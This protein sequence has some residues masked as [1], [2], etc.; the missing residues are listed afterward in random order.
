MDKLNS[1]NGFKISL[2]FSIV[3]LYI[4]FIDPMGIK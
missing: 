4:F 3:K 1:K 2:I